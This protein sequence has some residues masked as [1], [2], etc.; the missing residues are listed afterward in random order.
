[1]PDVKAVIFDLDGCPVDSEPHSLAAV[2]AELQALGLSEVTA[3][4]IGKRY[5]GV[6]LKAIRQDAEA[7]TGRAAPEDFEARFERR[8]FAAYDTGLRVI[9]G[10]PDL[11][12]RLVARGLPIAIASGGTPGRIARTLGTV[13][14]ERYFDG[15]AFSADQV[16]RGKPAP[17]LFLLA[18]RELGIA[19]EHCLVVEDSPHGIEGTRRA[20]MQPLGF[21]GGAHL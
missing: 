17:D 4:D 20:G 6:S 15:R 18:A 21:V 1:M 13:G 3:E 7:E 16:A 19:P 5:L 8:L 2:A 11:L 10:V 9:D 14:L 12:E